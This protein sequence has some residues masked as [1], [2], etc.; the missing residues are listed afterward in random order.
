MKD[1]VRLHDLRERTTPQVE[2]GAFRTL[3]VFRCP[4]C[5]AHTNLVRTAGWGSARPRHYPH[6][7]CPHAGQDWHNDI[8]DHF[9]VFGVSDS[10]T[11]AFRN[12]HAGKGTDDIVGSPDFSQISVVDHIHWYADG[13]VFTHTTRLRRLKYATDGW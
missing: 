11:E 12:L 4:A 13:K 5:G 2:G 9:A 10:R 7:A 6:A 8:A 3:Q 1:D